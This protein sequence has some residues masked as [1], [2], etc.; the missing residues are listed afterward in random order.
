MT[1]YLTLSLTLLAIACGTAKPMPVKLASQAPQAREFFKQYQKLSNTFD[2]N[3]M[4]LYADDAQISTTRILPDGRLQKLAFTGA[5]FKPIAGKMLPL[6]QLRDDTSTFSNV[7]LTEVGDAV[8]ITAN[9]YSKLKCYTDIK[10]YLVLRNGPSGSL[11]IAEE[12]SQTRSL[13]ICRDEDP[14]PLIETVARKY[15][16]KLPIMADAV[17]R[18]DSVLVNDTKLLYNFTLVNVAKQEIDISAFT[19][20]IRS[21]VVSQACL[22]PDFRPILDNGASISYRYNDEHDNTVANIKVTEWDC[23]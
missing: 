13:S 5:E 4:E 18:L 16:G 20:A 22:R 10:F 6:A 15:V 1:K 11:E 9:R 8:K 7:K 19:A 12:H 3:L 21:G 14:I 17:S 23:L 2:Q